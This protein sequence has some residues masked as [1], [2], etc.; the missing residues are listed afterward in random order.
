MSYERLDVN[1]CRVLIL[2]VVLAAAMEV[3]AQEAVKKEQESL[4]G[5]WSVLRAIHDGHKY[6]PE[7]TKSCKLSIAGD[8]LTVRCDK[9]TES[10]FSV[11]ST[12]KPHA[13]DVTPSD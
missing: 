12:K 10:Q 2:A 5:T 6:P 3:S 7:K 8:K 4:Q 11:D 13:I 1:V 9:P